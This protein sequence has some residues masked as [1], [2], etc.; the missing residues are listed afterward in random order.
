[1][2]LLGENTWRNTISNVAS[3]GWWIVSDSRRVRSCPHAM[4]FVTKKYLGQ[5]HH[6]SASVLYRMKTDL[7]KYR[8]NSWDCSFW[9]HKGN[10][11]SDE[12]TG[13]VAIITCSNPL[14]VCAVHRNILCSEIFRNIFCSKILHWNIFCSKISCCKIF[15]WRIFLLKIAFRLSD[16]L[17]DVERFSFCRI[18]LQKDFLWGI[19]LQKI[20]LLH[21]D[22]LQQACLPV[23]SFTFCRDFL[24]AESYH[25][26]IFCRE[27][28]QLTNQKL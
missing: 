6:S 28:I 2:M 10:A 17:C 8:Q 21:K 5:I 26:N 20:C 25:R 3:C 12:V 23:A 22:F 15:S 11:I 1:M 14:S 18:F 19:F 24:S 9:L 13:G 16:C 7:E 4:F 27:I